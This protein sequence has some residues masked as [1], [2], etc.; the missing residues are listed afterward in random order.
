MKLLRM[1]L[2]VLFLLAVLMPMA[3]ATDEVEA[4]QWDAIDT[5][6]I[7]D[8]AQDAGVG[9]KLGQ[10][11]DLQEGLA[12]VVSLMGET[13]QKA[14]GAATKSAILLLV[15]VL[16]CETVGM[17]FAT[18]KGQ[19]ESI[20]A[21]VGALAVTTIAV[22]DVS[23]LIGMAQSSIQRIAEFAKLLIPVL[24]ACSAATGAVT[25]ATARQA[26]TLLLANVLLT[27]I[28][29]VLIP[30]VYLYVGACAAC[31]ALGNE[32]LGTVAKLFRWCIHTIL[33]TSLLLFTIYLS[34][35]N[36]AAAGADA[37]A[38]KLTRTVISSLVPVVG[39]ILSD[40]SETVLA[41]AGL[42][43][44]TVGLFGVVAVLAWCVGPFLYLGAQYLAYRV[45]AVLSSL[46]SGGKTAKLIEQISGAFGLVLGMTGAVALLVMISLFAT[47]SVV[48][49]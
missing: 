16:F 28:E 37:V 1:L 12:Q 46:V 13:L 19:A 9:L 34:L 25:A 31:A 4:A 11:F 17:F 8:A 49:T 45:V 35:T 33:T 21:L 2:A 36:F 48:V 47:L 26:A 30:F 24:T 32:G 42:V 40:A 18:A 22:T 41:G 5:Q 15:V 29:R 7:E 38:I 39:G 10:D 3:C 23:S 14:V 6:S 44:N 27:L 43:R 20:T